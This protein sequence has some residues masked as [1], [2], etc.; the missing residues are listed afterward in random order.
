MIRLSASHPEWTLG[1]LDEVWW[2]RLARPRLHTWEEADRPL[3]LI[4]LSVAK[5]D[6]E[7]KALACYGLLVR[8]EVDA[9]DA[10]WLRFVED[11][12]V[13]TITTQF[14][15]WCCERLELR[16]KKALLLVWDNASWHISRE[17]RDWIRQHNRRVKGAGSG[18][19]IV[20]CRLP[21]KSPWL[22]PIEAKWTHGKKR[23]VEADRLLTARELAER[24]CAAYG[25]RY[26]PHLAL[27]E[28]VA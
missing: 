27:P 9:S 24:V 12:P 17:V 7:P 25:C 6:P 5:D 13:S 18:V 15:T 26:E 3:H 21:S 22:N 28:K 20:G 23:V 10:M 1:F 4:E 19:R 11:R 14:L 8:G 16:G 2:S